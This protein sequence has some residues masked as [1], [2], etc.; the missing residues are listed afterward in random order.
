MDWKS[1]VDARLRDNVERTKHREF[2]DKWQ[3]DVREYQQKTLGIMNSVVQE[4][5]EAAERCKFPGASPHYVETVRHSLFGSGTRRV[6]AGVSY[7]SEHFVPRASAL[8]SHPPGIEVISNGDWTYQ[9]TIQYSGNR[10]YALY[11]TCTNRSGELDVNDR[12]R[13]MLALGA[14]APENA[15]SALAQIAVD[16]C[17]KL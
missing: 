7:S 6:Q 14:T 10:D 9:E 12:T 5:L 4:F 2:S 11:L 16:N 8:S 1:H 3:N 17:I 13:G 15:M